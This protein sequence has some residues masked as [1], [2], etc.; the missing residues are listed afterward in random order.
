[1]SDALRPT[2]YGG[3]CECPG[4]H[5]P[6][7]ALDGPCGDAATWTVMIIRGQS[8]SGRSVEQMCASCAEQARRLHR[9]DVCRVRPI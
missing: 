2:D 8:D 9:E 5:A 3:Y 7:P 6:R 4:R 1:M